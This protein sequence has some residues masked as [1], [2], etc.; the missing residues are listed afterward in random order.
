MNTPRTHQSPGRVYHTDRMCRVSDA[1]QKTYDVIVVG[2][3]QPANLADI[4]VRGGLSAV[5][6]E[7]ELVGGDCSYWACIPSKALLRGPKVLGEAGAV[8]GAGA[9]VTGELDVEETVARRSSFTGD[10]DD[11]GQ[12]KSVKDTGIDLLRGTGRLDGERTVVVTAADGTETRLTARHAVAMCTGS[13][14]AMPPI[15]GLRGVMPWTP[16][17]ATSTKEVPGRLVVVGGGVV[18]C[19]MAT[20]W[21]TLSSTVTVIELANR[22]LPPLEPEAGRRWPRRCATVAPTSGSVRW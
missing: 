4:V 9:A 13:Q 2:G 1:A 7:A 21:R 10:G 15:D 18:G 14:A 11:S 12:V 19:E 22:L 17:E 5:L 6:V 8:R 16:R 3:D 20:A